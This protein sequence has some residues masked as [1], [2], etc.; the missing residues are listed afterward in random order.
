[1]SVNWTGKEATAAKCN[2]CGNMKPCFH[3]PDPW[4]LMY[5]PEVD[6][7]RGQWCRPCYVK[8]DKQGPPKKDKAKA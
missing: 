4:Q 6:P 3:V 7:D 8:R 1:M 5:Q 2:R